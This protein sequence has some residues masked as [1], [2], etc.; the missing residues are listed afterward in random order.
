MRDRR[1]T[2]AGGVQAEKQQRYAQLI[3]QGSTTRR[4]AGCR[5]QPQDRHAVA[6]WPTGPKFRL[7]ARALLA[8]RG[9]IPRGRCANANSS[10]GRPGRPAR[11]RPARILRGR[12][13]RGQRNSHG[14]ARSQTRAPTQGSQPR[15]ISGDPAHLHARC[16]RPLLHLRERPLDSVGP[17]DLPALLGQVDRLRSDAAAHVEGSSRRERARPSTNADSSA[18]TCPGPT[19]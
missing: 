15:Y 17:R 13:G 1:R 14:R 10:S 19:A 3:A 11:S 6:V 16:L 8:P 12:R 7:A 2:P 9:P 18:A 4:R 5:D